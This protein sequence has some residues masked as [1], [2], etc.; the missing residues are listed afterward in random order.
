MKAGRGILDADM[1]TIAG[2]IRQGFGWW[3]DE[4]ADLVPPALRLSQARRR[5]LA[6]Y[7]GERAEIYWEE[8]IGTKGASDR[9]V[10][11]DLAVTSSQA[12][13]RELSIPVMRDADMRSYIL[14]ESDRL[15]PLAG[16]SLLVDAERG[17]R[18]DTSPQMSIR[19][20]AIER[21]VAA[22]AI[23]AAREAGVL[24][25][26]I[27]IAT[28]DSTA[29]VA[30]DFAPQLRREGQLPPRGRQRA[31]W[32][33]VVAAVFLLNLGLLVWRDRQSVVVLAQLVESQRPAV[34]VYRAI[35]VRTARIDQI[36][37]RT[38]ARRR[39]HN[40]LAD[41]GAVSAALPDAAW[42]QRYGWDGRTMRIAG[43][44]R[45]QTDVLAVLGHSNRFANAR[46]SSSEL[47]A[48]NLG[49]QPF[50][51]SADI[52]EEHR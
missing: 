48:E 37:R 12:L 10:N 47:Q 3:K 2:W 39:R 43:Y 52:V 32:W 46:S 19:V 44:M 22:A 17:K 20:A 31:I 40:A 11:A 1:T 29:A 45:A 4:L 5:P 49:G 51:I 18:D 23:K 33:G 16:D 50:D 30:F 41:L 8:N 26:R 13:I 9:P 15:F 27:G 34:G 35:A 6:I 25:E 38:I 24:P 36:E 42:V 28:N 7:A 14:L 21:T